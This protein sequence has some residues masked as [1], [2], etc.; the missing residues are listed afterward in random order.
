M[1]TNG[2]N[3]YQHAARLKYLDAGYESIRGSGVSA[4]ASTLSNSQCNTRIV[5]YTAM[6][7]VIL[8][9]NG[10]LLDDTWLCV[11]SLNAQLAKQGLDAV[12]INRYREEFG[13]PVRDFYVNLGF[14]FSTVSY[15]Q[16][17]ESFHH[18]YNIR[19]YSCS[20]H[21][22]VNEL[23]DWCR[24]K[25]YGPSILSV[26]RESYLLETLDFYQLREKVQHIV[27]QADEYS[28]GKL[29]T[30]KKL[31]QVLAIDPGQVVLVGDSDHDFEVARDLGC[32]CILVDHGHNSTDRLKLRG[33]P[34]VSSLRDVVALLT[35]Y[36][37]GNSALTDKQS[38]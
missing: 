15:E 38:P 19:R 6:Q 24:V 30:G 21:P 25:G 32:C 31:L 2:L 11:E 20:L 28:I 12:N 5:F 1:S 27:G 4:V 18:Y 37:N 34:V 10:T 26:Y 14:D 22:Y 8:D 7:H 35:C 9:W 29:Q 33:A 13:F 36:G 23:I 17:A 3:E 16:I